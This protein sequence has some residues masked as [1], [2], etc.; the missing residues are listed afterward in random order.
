VQTAGQILDGK[1]KKGKKPP[2][3]DGNTAKRIIKVFE[4]SVS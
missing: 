3:W 2:Y 1:R 4:K